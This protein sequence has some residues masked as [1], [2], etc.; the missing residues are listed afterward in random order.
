MLGLRS[1]SS[2]A[3]HAPGPLAELATRGVMLSSSGHVL[4]VQGL[5]QACLKTMNVVRSLHQSSPLF[6]Q[7][8]R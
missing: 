1:M 4:G 3:A 5:P 6:Q 8:D 2:I 7:P